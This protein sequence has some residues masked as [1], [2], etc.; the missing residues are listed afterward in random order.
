MGEIFFW[1]AKFYSFGK[2][3]FTWLKIWYGTKLV[4]FFFLCKAKN[5]F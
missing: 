3:K 1:K 2:K 4:F 5:I